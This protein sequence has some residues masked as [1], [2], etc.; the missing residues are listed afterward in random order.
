MFLLASSNMIKFVKYSEIPLQEKQNINNLINEEFGG[1]SF[2]SETEWSSP[3]WT[4]C[5]EEN[6]E[7]LAF[8]NIIIRTVSFDSKDYKIAGI[9]NVITLKNHRNKGY[10]FKIM[11]E[12]TTFIFDQLEMDYGLLLCADAVMPFYNKIGWYQVDSDLYYEQS[13]G[14]KLYD[15]NT[16]VLSKSEPIE[17]T[18]IDLNG[19]PW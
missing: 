14:I 15:S 6:N 7:T 4:I 8:L 16:M 13:T 1:I 11:N 5:L 10:A 12:A 2:V 9:N 18:K 17:P 3:D 19:L